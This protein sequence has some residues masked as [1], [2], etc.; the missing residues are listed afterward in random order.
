MSDMVR[1]SGPTL[2]IASNPLRLFGFLRHRIQDNS[3]GTSHDVYR[4]T[5]DPA[6][7]WPKQLGAAWVI[8]QL[9]LHLW[10]VYRGDWVKLAVIP[11][12]VWL[13][14]LLFYALLPDRYYHQSR[15]RPDISLRTATLQR[16]V[17]VFLAACGFRL[18]AFAQHTGE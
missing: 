17:D 6:P 10:L 13:A 5:E 15:V 16:K 2:A 3:F 18:W 1:A 12:A 11:T 7:A 4:S 8:G 14:A 9:P